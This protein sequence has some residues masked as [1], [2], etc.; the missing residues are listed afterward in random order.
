MER[1]AVLTPEAEPTPADGARTPGSAVLA[2]E[3]ELRPTWLPA[4]ASD[5]EDRL[6]PLPTWRSGG[7]MVDIN[8]R[9]APCRVLDAD[10]DPLY[11]KGGWMPLPGGC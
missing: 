4:R 7:H 11:E 8:D 10:C 2:P 5:E 1:D 9:E 6:A 3:A